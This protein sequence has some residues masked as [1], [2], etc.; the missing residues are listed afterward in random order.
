MKKIFLLLSL[1]TI[2]LYSCKKE[3]AVQGPAGP[4]G[5][6]GASGFGKDTG[7]SSGN[8]TLYN[9]FTFPVADSSGV[10]V[11]LRSGNFQQKTSSDTHGHYSFSGIAVGTYNLTYEKE[12]FGTMKVFGLS[13]IPGGPLPTFVQ[14]IALLQLPVK[15]AIKSITGE[16]SYTYYRLRILLDTSSNSYLQYTGNLVVLYGNTADVSPSHYLIMHSEYVLNDPATGGYTDYIDKSSLAGYFNPG[17]TVYVTA[18][19][20][21]RYVHKIKEPGELFDLG[22]AGYYI[23]PANGRYV[24]PNISQPA[25]ALTFQ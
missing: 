21:S 17:D 9:E 14:D 22:S 23:D 19:T 13:H 15:T 25:A 16:D 11:T 12:G 3:V 5:E 8:L 4:A 18:C 20:Y 24:Y 7:T 1:L 2:I 6:S 10:A